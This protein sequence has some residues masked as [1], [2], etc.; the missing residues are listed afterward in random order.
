[1]INS[2]PS[3]LQKGQIPLVILRHYYF[4]QMTKWLHLLYILAL[5]SQRHRIHWFFCSF[6]SISL[7]RSLTTFWY[8]VFSAYFVFSFY[9]SSYFISLILS[10]YSKRSYFIFYCSSKLFCSFF[11]L[12]SSNLFLSSSRFFNFYSSFSITSSFLI[13]DLSISSFYFIIFFIS[14]FLLDS[15]SIFLFNS[16]ASR[17][18]FFSPFSFCTFG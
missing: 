11:I 17:Y 18:F 2:P 6:Y 4:S 16:I 7:L 8:S 3:I 5:G 10:S 13:F 9:F 14:F 12:L 15:S 1:M